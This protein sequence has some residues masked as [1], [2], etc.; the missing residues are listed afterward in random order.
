LIIKSVGMD[1]IPIGTIIEI[2][3]YDKWGG[4]SACARVIRLATRE[5][6][7]AEMRRED[8]DFEKHA[9]SYAQVCPHERHYEVSVD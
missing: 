5:E 6:Y 7:L 9:D 3:G 8:P 2:Y 1:E 4:P